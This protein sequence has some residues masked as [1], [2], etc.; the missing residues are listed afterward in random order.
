MSEGKQR[1]PLF[2]LFRAILKIIMLPITWALYVVKHPLLIAVVLLVIALGLA[3][4]PMSKGVK[5][6]DVPSWYMGKSKEISADVVNAVAESEG[7]VPEALKQEA[8]KVQ[9]T[10][11]EEKAEEKRVKSENYNKK[12]VRDA[13]IETEVDELRNRKGFKKK[14]SVEEGIK[15]PDVLSD[16]KIDALKNK[17]AGGIGNLLKKE[18]K[19]AVVDVKV[20]EEPEESENKEVKETAEEEDTVDGVLQMMDDEYIAKLEAKKNAKKDEEDNE[21]GIFDLF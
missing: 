17:Q 16:D 7:I 14:Q 18:S 5:L 3:Y 15:K 11:E 10:I 20:I 4:Y 2:K 21:G 8:K 19:P 12:I 1:S 6:A 9:K 13:K